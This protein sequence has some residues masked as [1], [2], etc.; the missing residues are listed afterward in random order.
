MTRILNAAI[1][2]AATAPVAAA[3]PILFDFDGGPLHTPTPFDQTSGGLTAHFSDQFY[4]YSI[5]IPS[6]SLGV[7]PVGF[8]GY[9]LVPSSVFKCDLYIDFS[10]PLT[11]ISML[12]AP[13]ELDCDSS[14]T[15]R[16]SVYSGPNFIGTALTTVPQPG[17]V[18]PTGTLAYSSAQTFDHVVIHYE[19]PPPTGGD[20]GVIFAIDNIH[21]TPVPEPAVATGVGVALLGLITLRKRH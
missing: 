3:Q 19:S 8:S 21:A 5:Q 11:E 13:H 10:T 14:A 12:Y 4:G 16:I 6:Q 1:M 2:L 7:T 18:W 20:Y 17:G 9:S 15:M